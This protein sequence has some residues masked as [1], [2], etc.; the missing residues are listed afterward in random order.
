MFSWVLNK[1]PQNFKILGKQ[2]RNLVDRFFSQYKQLWFE[3]PP[4]AADVCLQFELV[5]QLKAD[6][7]RP[8]FQQ[9][10]SH[11][12]FL[13]ILVDII[14]MIRQDGINCRHQR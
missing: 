12:Q 1:Q 2:T 5:I 11:K 14:C 4:G 8:V 9:F 10:S 6:W 3:I 7:L 13:L